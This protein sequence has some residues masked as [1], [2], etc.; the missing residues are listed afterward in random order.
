MSLHVTLVFA[1]I[2]GTGFDSLARG[3]DGGWISHGL[4]VV[5]AAAQ[6][7]GHRVD[8]VDLRALTDWQAFQQ[9]IRQRAPAVVGFGVLSVDGDSVKEAATR[10]K[11]CDPNIVTVAGGPHVTLAT[12]DAR[13]FPA[14]DYLVTG[15]GEVAFVELLDALDEGRPP[16]KRIIEGTRADLD[17]TPPADR[18]LFLTEWRQRGYDLDSPEVPFVAE[19]PPPFATLMAGRGC[20]FNCTF[21]KPGTD[22]LFGP[23]PRWRRVAKVLDELMMLRQRYGLNSYMF[24][25]DCLTGNRA[26]VAEFVQVCRQA[27]IDWPFFAQSRPDLI[28]SHADTIEQLTTVGLKGLL[29][30]FESGSQRILDLLNKGTTVAQ[31]LEAARICKRLGLSVW[32]N[33]MLGIPTET[34]EDAMATVKMLKAIDPDYYSPAFFTPYPGTAL[35]DFVRDRD[36]SLIRRSADYRRNPTGPKIKGVDYRFMSKALAMSRRRTPVNRLR[37]WI[38]RQAHRAVRALTG[39]PHGR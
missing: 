24:H 21:C 27:R 20:P 25:D 23:A 22:L 29:I 10:V 19:L 34:R 4:A 31:N 17:Q 3:M 11:A 26:W 9:Q 18:E 32:A 7:R 16:S 38:G 8:L 13:T 6:A 12:D 2:A 5:G 35:Y 30:G 15:E 36:L 33:Y 14:I 39:E 1:G 28:V 37:R